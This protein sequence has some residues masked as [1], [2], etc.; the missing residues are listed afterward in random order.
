MLHNIAACHLQNKT[1]IKRQKKYA[2]NKEAASLYMMEYREKKEDIVQ[3][4][5]KEYY[6]SKMKITMKVNYEGNKNEKK[7]NYV[8][9]KDAKKLYFQE[10]YKENKD[11][12]RQCYKENIDAK[13]ILC[14]KQRC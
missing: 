2:Q 3:L 6:K 11:D 10:Y 8:H 14:R 7:K 5:N 1:E 12:K 9:K 13:A 4:S